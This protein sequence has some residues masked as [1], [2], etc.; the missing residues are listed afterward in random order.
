MESKHV[1][2]HLVSPSSG[3]LI[4]L[5][6]RSV[7]GQLEN[8]NAER[9]V[10]NLVRSIERVNEVL[11]VI[12]ETRGVVFHTLSEKTN[13]RALE[14]GCG[15]LDVPCLFVLEPF[16]STL[17][18]H[19]GAVVRFRASPRDMMDEEY[20]RR[21]DAMRFTLAH[22]DGIGGHDIESAEVVLVGVSR[23]TKTP[24]CMYLAHRGVRAANVPL[25]P[26]MPVVDA[27][28]KTKKPLIVGLTMQPEYLV[29]IRAKRLTMLKQNPGDAYADLDVVRREVL[30]ARRLF[31]RNNWP[32]IDVTSQSIEQT[33]AMIMELLKVRQ[34]Q[35][36]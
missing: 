14:E 35:R 23:V 16:V 17:A 10:W 18:D 31:A 28:S 27:L 22:D 24:T 7:L 12:A 1:V 2:L 36:V 19:T 26:G 5:L 15:V 11:A 13:R 3:E 21:L 4:D 9:F 29:R 8:L 6:A 20:F 32:V 25:V 34:A 33:S 30:D